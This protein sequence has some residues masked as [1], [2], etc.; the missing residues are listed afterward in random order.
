MANDVPITP[1]SGATVATDETGGKHYQLIK[2]VSGTEDATDRI[3]GDATNGLD[4]DVTRIIPGT[5]AAALGKAEDAAHTSGDTGVMVLGVRN[6]TG[7]AL[8]GTAGD[9]IPL[10]MD[11][12][13]YLRVNVV[14]G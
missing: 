7:V 12:N 8:A 9:Y 5:T 2:L 1:G 6:D 11:A 13:G 14:T 10:S 3:G 4:V